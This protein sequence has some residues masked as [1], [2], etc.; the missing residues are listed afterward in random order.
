[1]SADA[2]A[3]VHEGD[4]GII[5]S[6]FQR[7]I[8]ELVAVADHHVVTRGRVIREGGGDIGGFQVLGVGQVESVLLTGLQGAL[9]GG[10]VPPLVVDRAGHAQRHLERSRG[11]RDARARQ[12]QRHHQDQYQAEQLLHFL[13]SPIELH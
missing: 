3:S 12:R 1:L 9:I 5:L 13:S 4:V 10:L 8:A 7:R 6:H 2:S 11:F